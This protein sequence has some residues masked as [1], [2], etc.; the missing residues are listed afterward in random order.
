M[1]GTDEEDDVVGRTSGNRHCID[2]YFDGASQS[3]PGPAG[4]GFAIYR[5][6]SDS[7][8]LEEVDHSSQFIGKASNNVAE[9]R[10]ALSAL[11][12]ALRHV[13][14]SGSVHL[15]GDSNLV[16]KQLTGE[17]KT[18]NTV[19]RK[20]RGAIRAVERR[21]GVQTRWTYIPRCR[22]TRAD[23]L[24]KEA[25]P[26]ENQTA[27][28]GSSRRSDSLG[29]LQA[30]SHQEVNLN[31]ACP[32]CPAT[33]TAITSLAQHLRRNHNPQNV[34][35]D[36]IAQWRL[37]RCANCGHIF[38]NVASHLKYCTHP[39]P[40][41]APKQRTG[42]FRTETDET[43]LEALTHAAEGDSSGW[44]SLLGQER[45]LVEPPAEVGD[46]GEYELTPASKEDQLQA[47]VHHLS[48][49][50]IR[51]AGRALTS[52]G[53]A[54]ESHNVRKQLHQ[55]H[56]HQ[57]QDFEF[58]DDSTYAT[59]NVPL[60][61]VKKALAG[62][63]SDSAPGPSG[64]SVNKIKQLATTEDGA[65]AITRITNR[66]LNGTEQCKERLLASRLIPLIKSS[67]KVR[68]IA[69]G[70]VITRLAGR[71]LLRSQLKEISNYLKPLQKGVAEAAGTE[72]IVHQ[73]RQDYLNGHAVL[74]LDISNAF[75]TLSRESIK[76]EVERNLPYLLP[77]YQWAYQAAS[78]LEYG[79]YL[80]TWSREG[81]RQGDP[82]GPVFF[83]IGFHG[84]LQQ[85]SQEF[86]DVSIS[87]YLDDVSV[88][89][90]V[91]ALI[92]VAKRFKELAA[93]RGLTVNLEKSKLLVP[94]DAQEPP[95][96]SD[97]PIMRDG[98]ELL[99]SPI[100]T[101]EFESD[102]CIQRVNH[103][104]KLALL[105][106]ES[107]VPVQN[108]YLLLKDA[109]LPTLNYLW[110][111]VP[112][113]NRREAVA[114]LDKT[115]VKITKRLLGASAFNDSTSINRC[116]QI[117]LP[118][119][120]G[121][122]GITRPACVSLAAYTASLRESGVQCPEHVWTSL[123]SRLRDFGAD[124]TL[125]Q[126][127]LNRLLRSNGEDFRARL[128][129]AQETG[130][131][132]WLRAL[133]TSYSKTFTDLQWR[134]AARLRLGLRVSQERFP[135]L[136][137]LCNSQIYNIGHHAFTCNYIHMRVAQNERHN[138]LRDVLLGALS[139][140][141]FEL[142]K[143]PLIKQGQSFRGDIGVAHPQG[144]Q[145]LDV[146]VIHPS[147]VSTQQNNRP[148]AAT[149]VR[150]NEKRSKYGDHCRDVDKSFIPIVFQTFGGIGRHTLDFLSE[151]QSRPPSFKVFEPV[152][153]VG[154]LRTGL[155]CR[156]M[157]SNTNLLIKWLQ[158]VT[159]ASSGGVNCAAS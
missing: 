67:K 138:M 54:P 55:L 15:R 135:V 45:D 101:A 89:G 70:E 23:F 117:S 158:L 41:E 75:N 28:D 133:P 69:I 66:I 137:P 100:G 110:R 155:G 146:S 87:A 144:P 72:K 9:Y 58:T 52:K 147:V 27:N 141:G 12:T 93:S 47:A 99:G 102:F 92:S 123:V 60:A 120:Y 156:F 105:D 33:Y 83:A 8:V 85:L 46:T 14:P 44:Y 90:S 43:L 1:E 114:E 116:S 95:D 37:G 18:K 51:K 5:K 115:V 126:S 48:K 111:T 118:L 49:G 42:L 96:G 73:V 19:L 152:K 113:E 128:N 151:L 64:L 119:R 79:S 81:V 80:L 134:L 2:V 16:I 57:F 38:K 112:P 68:P 35:D 127:H 7:A 106:M 77:Y 62:M 88:T 17:W 50:S 107:A 76:L 78:P 63:H 149:R 30:H 159:P 122:L 22:N 31:I 86:L 71:V 131:S 34:G 84:I 142:Q 148:A 130:S 74:S 129:A 56:P 6:S 103:L 91:D 11:R 124:V 10:A 24:A 145:I 36:F 61:T 150:E 98:I 21:S 154:A 59:W 108:R 4:I 140:W 3:N 32:L 109:V 13:Y 153:F 94:P 26:P 25:I 20:L 65:R 40:K 139:T 97:L 82:L 132:D 157:R 121:G 136:C 29:D 53:V 125:A 104:G 39:P 143:E